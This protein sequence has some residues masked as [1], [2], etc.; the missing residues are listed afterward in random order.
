MQTS[1]CEMGGG[2]RAR[3]AQTWTNRNAVR[4][5]CYPSVYI[6]STQRLEGQTP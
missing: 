6:A 4:A 3:D 5:G 1:E 2:W